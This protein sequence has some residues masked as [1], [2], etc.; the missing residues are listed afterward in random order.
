MNLFEQALSLHQSGKFDAA[1]AIYEQ[2]H[3]QNKKNPSVLSLLGVAECQRGNPK[4]GVKHLEKSLKLSPT[5]PETHND[6]GNAY[7]ELG[8][9]DDAIASYKRAIALNPKFTPAH[10]NLGNVFQDRGKHKEALICY[11]SALKIDPRFSDA[12]FNRGNS[13]HELR[14]FDEAVADYDKAI[15]IDPTF[16]EAQHNRGNALMKL[17]RYTEAIESLDAA[18]A[19][20]PANFEAINNKGIA[21]QRLDRFAEAIA[22]YDQALAISSKYTAAINNKGNAFK[23]LGDL[24]KAMQCY[25][26]AIEADSEFADAHLNK[27]LLLLLRGDFPAGLPLY[28]WRWKRKNAGKIKPPKAQLWLGEDIANKSIYIYPEQGLGD[29]LQY[30]RYVDVVRKIAGKVILE[31]PAPLEGLMEH[32]AGNSCILVKEGEA[33]PHFDFHCPIM[34]LPLACN[35]V[36]DTIPASI[37]YLSTPKAKADHW[38]A[39]LGEKKQPRIGLVW[40]GN[41]SHQLDR[42]R[43]IPL[44]MFEP[45][46][47][48]PFEFHALQKDIRSDDAEALKQIQ[49]IKVYCNELVDFTDTA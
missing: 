15:A 31:V 6:L 25:D 5:Q 27:S 43:S 45:I 47:S 28:E 21:L 35:T 20:S 48:M 49:N 11:A 34:T 19:R 46:L 12:Y 37:P 8:R 29:Y 40:S 3:G 7:K 23:H 2:L 42:H 4:I 22:C 33:I 26:Q 16:T 14:R 17:N 36:L 32:F 9:L 38:R 39:K 41:P 18:I 1:I 30:V 44:K 10:N 24:Q 13:L